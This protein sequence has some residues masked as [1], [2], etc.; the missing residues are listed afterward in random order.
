VGAVSVR[1]QVAVPVHAP[2]HPEKL[3]LL[4]G[5]AVSVM[6]VF[7][8][9]LAAHVVGQLIPAGLLV[10]TPVPLPAVVTVSDSLVALNVALTFSAAAM[11]RV[12]AAVPEHA[13][14]HPEKTELLPAVA[15]SVIFVF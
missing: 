7:W 5:V 11:V 8:G 14:L 12:Q 2:L 4:V 3:S 13:P 1:L 6:A 15:V 10:T 9:K